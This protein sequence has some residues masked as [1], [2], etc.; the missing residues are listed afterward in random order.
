MATADQSD[1]T[2][3]PESPKRPA[4]KVQLPTS[5]GDGLGGSLRNRKTRPERSNLPNPAGASGGLP[6][7]GLARG[8]P[9]RATAK[10]LRSSQ[11]PAADS[12]ES[13]VS[14]SDATRQDMTGQDATRTRRPGATHPVASSMPLTDGPS[15][16]VTESHFPS[17]PTVPTDAVTAAPLQSASSGTSKRPHAVDAETDSDVTSD[18]NR[19]DFDF[20]VPATEAL[21]MTIEHSDVDATE[22][23]EFDGGVAIGQTYSPASSDVNVADTDLG[24]SAAPH[25]DAE[26][27][28]AVL[29]RPLETPQDDS[30]G[31][32]AAADLGNEIDPGRTLPAA[33]PSSDF[34]EE[35][36][37][38]ITAWPA[39]DTTDHIAPAPPRTPKGT[40]GSPD[41]EAAAPR[42]PVTGPDQPS[43]VASAKHRADESPESAV[44]SQDVETQRYRSGISASTI[45]DVAPPANDYRAAPSDNFGDGTEVLSTSTP[46]AGATPASAPVESSP[47]STEQFASPDVL[48]P[49]EQAAVA[50]PV[51]G[52]PMLDMTEPTLATP[53]EAHAEPVPLLPPGQ[54]IQPTPPP[55]DPMPMPP[56]DPS[57]SHPAEVATTGPGPTPSQSNTPYAAPGDRTWAAPEL[58]SPLADSGPTVEQPPPPAAAAPVDLD[59]PAVLQ[60]GH[61][62][63]APKPMHQPSLSNQTSAAASPDELAMSPASD[64]DHSAVGTADEP[65][66]TPA[67]GDKSTA[68]DFFAGS[69]P[70]AHANPDPVSPDAV[71]PAQPV[72]PTTAAATSSPADLSTPTPGI[73]SP[74][75]PVPPAGP[76][77]LPEPTDGHQTVDVSYPPA[78]AR[79]ASGRRV[80]PASQDQSP[81]G[82]DPSGT[83]APSAGASAPTAHSSGQ[84]ARHAAPLDHV[85]PPETAVRPA[86]V[87]QPVRVAARPSNPRVPVGQVV[88][89]MHA[90]KARYGRDKALEQASMRAVTGETIAVIGP[91]GAGK[92]TLLGCCSGR[93]NT[94]GGK[95]YVDGKLCKSDVPETLRAAKVVQMHIQQVID[96]TQT[97]RQYLA[98][99]P[100]AEL[101]GQA[102]EDIVFDRFPHLR[103]HA[104]RQMGQL[105][106][107]DHRILDLAATLTMDPRIVIV[108]D[109]AEGLDQAGV[110]TLAAICREVTSMGPGLVI[111]NREPH[112]ALDIASRVTVVQDRKTVKHGA[113]EEIRQILLDKGI[114]RPH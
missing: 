33:L 73:A 72:A 31:T 76:R 106:Q 98:T 13:K 78:P 34:G 28:P 2:P 41:C 104:E 85:N 83:S 9:G 89:E 75:T 94:S 12:P 82:A 25:A 56:V 6:R 36:T 39:D 110:D 27:G 7:P 81:S 114:L 26:V 37:E 67:E 68:D 32:P 55:V 57:P 23:V 5:R 86:A 3:K 4:A 48:A 79:A 42:Q 10:S 49:P 100:N 18:P 60:P 112:A 11:V 90:V 40:V 58:P 1:D 44:A 101:A 77:P 69:K 87:V 53:P 95:M 80:A 17:L 8:L 66:G 51:G 29:G 74:Q 47:R 96:T 108:D 91:R 105:T 52:A 43:P 62:P 59:A 99:N 64:A 50:F 71:G 54:L 103:P 38:L 93:V 21:P 102:V 20:A 16:G 109:I 24:Q 63:L 19:V 61:V 35:Q 15:Q 30:A 92:T 45:D 84:A 113:S 65:V 14:E 70:D 107:V 22:T 97:V 111:A 88:V 46:P